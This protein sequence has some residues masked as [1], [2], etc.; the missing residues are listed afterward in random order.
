KRGAADALRDVRK[1]SR[2]NHPDRAKLPDTDAPVFPTI[3]S[4]FNDPGVNCLFLALTQALDR[5]CGVAGRWSS[6]D[7]ARSFPTEF[8]SRDPLI[9]AARARYL[10][11]I[12][13]QGRAARAGGA[14][15]A[16]A[17]QR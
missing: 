13:S 5:E 8:R 4:R 6:P 3:A 9:P 15:R 1:Q 14:A 7:D 10:A 16:Q 17:A 11:E 12:A 2:R